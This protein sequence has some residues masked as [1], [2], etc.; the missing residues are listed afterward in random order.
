MAIFEKTIRSQNFDTLLHRLER[1]IV[2]GS[3]S[4]ELEALQ[5]RAQEK[6]ETF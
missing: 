6:V 4:A 1:E 3:W 5:Y 2:D